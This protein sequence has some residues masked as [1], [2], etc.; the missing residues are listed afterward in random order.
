MLVTGGAD[1]IGRGI[2]LAFARQ[3][4]TVVAADLKPLSLSDLGAHDAK[5]S[6]QAGTPGYITTI[7]CDAG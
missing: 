1:G 3:G 4:A 6:G 5:S 2:A 7:L